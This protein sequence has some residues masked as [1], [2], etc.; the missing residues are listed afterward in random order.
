MKRI[1]AV[2]MV[3]I[4][5]YSCTN[6]AKIS[7]D[8]DNGSI[9]LN[10]NHKSQQQLKNLSCS[11]DYT[12][13][14]RNMDPDTLYAEVIKDNKTDKYRMKHTP[15]DRGTKFQTDDGKSFFWSHHEEFTYYIDDEI[16]CSYIKPIKVDPTGSDLLQTYTVTYRS[17]R[18]LEVEVDHSE[19]SSIAELKVTNSGF[20]GNL[21]IKMRINPIKDVFLA[22]LD[23]NG[24]KELYIITQSVGSGTYGNVYAFISDKDLKI[25]PHEIPQLVFKGYMGHDA[26]YIKNSVLVREFPLYKKE[27]SN[28]NPTGGEAKVFYTLEENK[29]KILST[30]QY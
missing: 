22:D 12:I 26:F 13:R 5:T 8:N 19:S 4:L 1:I 29:L 17:G 10:N 14:Y 23:K 6:T 20:E 2:L 27:D 9:E 30:H 28:A 15:S 11:N 18:T 24:Y 16:I 25:I 7:V 21:S 3:A